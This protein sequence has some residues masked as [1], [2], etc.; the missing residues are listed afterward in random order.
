MIGAI[1]YSD[2][3]SPV[4]FR[5]HCGTQKAYRRDCRVGAGVL[6]FL[7]LILTTAAVRPVGALHLSRED[8]EFLRKK[9]TIVFVSQTRYPPFEFVDANGQHEGMM[10]DVIRWLAVEM[11]FQPV[12][13][14]TAFKKAQEAVLSGK[15]DILTSLFYSDL[16]HK[17]FEF[18]S[19]LYDVPASI[20]VRSERTDIKDIRDLNGKII[21][22][23]S[24]DYAKEFLESRNVTFDLL[25]TRDFASATDKVIAGQADAVIGDEQIVWYH[26]FSNRLTDRVKKV[27][28]PLYVGRN[29]M[30]GSKANAHLVSILNGGVEEARRTGVLE[31]INMKWLGSKLEVE[32]SWLTRHSWHIGAVG[33]VVFL[34][35]LW[36]WIWNIRLRS[37]VRKRT[38][39]LREALLSRQKSESLLKTIVS[40]SPVGIAMVEE[41][42]VKWTNEAW[43]HMFESPDGGVGHSTRILYPSETE[44]QRVGEVVY[45]S[46]G[47]EEV[48]E[49]EAQFSR[50]GGSIFQGH[51]RVKAIDAADSD[52]R[53]IGVLTD[54]SDRKRAEEA[55]ERSEQRLRQV[56]N[57]VPHFIFAKDKEG[58]FILA[59]EA[60]A[61][62]YGASV[63]DLIGKRDPD[64][65]VRPDEARSFRD[66]DAK[67]IESGRPLHIPEEYFTDS[68]GKL[69]VLQT[70]KIPFS[71]SGS[72]VPAVLSVSVDITRHR[73]LEEQLR[74]AQKME[75]IGQLA[76]GVAHDFNNLLTA[77]IGYSTVA[78]GQMQASDPN[79]QRVLQINRAAEQAAGLTRQLLA[80][81]RKA[82][83]DVRVLDLNVLIRDL[84]EMLR[85]LI[86]EDIELSTSL[87]PELWHV[88]VDPSQIEQIVINVAVNARD[89]MPRGG[90]LTMA[91][92][93]VVLNHEGSGSLPEVEPGPYV[94]FAVSDSGH[95]MSS[96]TLSRIFDPFFTTKGKGKGTGLGLSTVFGIVKQHR[97]HIS[98]DS[99]IGRGTTFKIYLPSME[100]D[101]RP[102]LP[103]EAP[104][105]GRHGF[106]TVLVVEDEE[107]VRDLACE[108][109][110]MLGYFPL[111]AAHPQQAIQVSAQHRGTI[112][113]LLT[114]VV[115]PQMDGRSLFDRLSQERP[116]MRVLFMSGY[117]DDAIV[118]HG[119]LDPCVHFLPKPFSTE[120][121]ACKIRE[122]L[123]QT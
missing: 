40:T 21:A 49:T 102:A 91:T 80:F 61:R 73:R 50:R 66:N 17:S 38:K 55:L 99:D 58:R 94:M 109:L 24:G 101:A 23:Q 13:T 6:V 44:Y 9:G 36:V 31:K 67:V 19:T 119:V 114:D 74:Q 86:G 8:Q 4:T 77:M 111:S 84:E 115:L 18:T 22:M 27:G 56:M 117:A 68:R 46:L 7:A 45:G 121:L 98:V 54:I 112:H 95:G 90:K 83:L 12:F 43:N 14:D 10:L 106:E 1:L 42:T 116:D 62:A 87:D 78:L 96:D 3:L 89:A 75:A 59:N 100:G 93:N 52:K 53:V 32:P 123:D 113:L 20:F 60:V 37:I 30:A 92:T 15:A 2:V 110:G 5:A 71:E 57:L 65:A 104:V 28:T 70:T 11:G 97:G 47:K 105:R 85:R 82:M 79:R 69:R 26:V 39:D 122:V 63:K 35:L 51:L 29:C 103:P 76:G 120:A 72:E 41:R 25:E 107:M 34:L 88:E 48:V 33:G 118:H 64:F 108:V 16:R 81:G